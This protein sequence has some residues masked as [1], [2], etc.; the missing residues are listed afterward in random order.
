MSQP[1]FKCPICGWTKAAP[2]TEADIAAHF[3]RFHPGADND[4]ILRKA[5]KALKDAVGKK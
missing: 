2:Y 4:D 3:N 5:G 1:A